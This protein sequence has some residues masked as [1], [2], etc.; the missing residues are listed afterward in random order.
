MSTHAVTTFAVKSW[1]EK[2]YVEYDGRKINT[3]QRRLHLSG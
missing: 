3:R 1:D 2:P